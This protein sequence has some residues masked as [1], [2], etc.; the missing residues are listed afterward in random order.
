M[1]MMKLIRLGAVGMSLYYA[2][3]KE[4]PAWLQGTA[5][6][7]TLGTMVELIGDILEG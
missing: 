2:G 6:M 1:K 4:P 3:K 5:V 7:A